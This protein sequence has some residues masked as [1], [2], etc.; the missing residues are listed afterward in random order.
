MIRLPVLLLLPGLA[1]AALGLVA[2][3]AALTAPP[4]PDF[5]WP[6]TAPPPEAPGLAA[7]D[8]AGPWPDLFGQATPLPDWDAAAE[9]EVFEAPDDVVWDTVEAAPPPYLRLRGLGSGPSGGWALVETDAGLVLIRPGG[10]VGEAH[11]LVE[12][13]TDR[14]TLD[15]PDG[16]LVVTFEADDDLPPDPP[17][18]SPRNL[19]R[20]TR[21]FVDG[22]GLPIPLPP[23]GYL[24]GP[25]TAIGDLR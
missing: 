23:P 22:G 3:Q 1:A 12:V 8:P 17:Q 24:A 11:V 25:G 16:P 13:G 9:V 10:A 4:P 6:D 15:G 5:A 14:I 20:F 21:F 2:L 7:P 19:D 18:T